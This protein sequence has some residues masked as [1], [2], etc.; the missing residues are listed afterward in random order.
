MTRFHVADPGRH[1][2]PAAL[3]EEAALAWPAPD[4]PGWFTYPGGDG[5]AGKRVCDRWPDIPEPCR[6][7]LGLMA[8]EPVGDLLGLGDCAPDLSLWGGG[9]HDLGPGAS[10][11]LHLDA[12]RHPHTG[13]ARAATSVLAVGGHWPPAWGGRLELWAPDGAAPA[14][15][16]EPE[17]GR[18]V[19]FAASDTA[20]HAVGPVTC[21]AGATRKT[22]AVF[23]YARPPLTPGRRPRAYFA[24]S[25]PHRPAG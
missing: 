5:S 6:R 4:W 23:W 8:L 18:L 24:D 1:G 7:L 13:L 11:G 10:L 15:L 20:W 14:A 12:D 21:P 17:G 22:L 19:H 3:V 2:L 25:P 16:V 9:M